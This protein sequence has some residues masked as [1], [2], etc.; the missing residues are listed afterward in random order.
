MLG[1]I[2]A[3]YL[4]PELSRCSAAGVAYPET[5][6]PPGCVWMPCMFMTH[7][8]RWK[9]K[10]AS[11]TCKE[12]RCRALS[13]T[14]SKLQLASKI[15]EWNFLLNLCSGLQVIQMFDKAESEYKELSGRKQI[16]L[17]DRHKIEQVV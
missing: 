7:R 11:S 10:E 16:V 1:S 2:P 15:A 13:H 4:S 5:V 14:L 17:N 9:V 12:A 3:G 6:E 8:S